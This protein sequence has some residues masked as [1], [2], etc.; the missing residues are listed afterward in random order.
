MATSLKSG[1]LVRETA[2]PLKRNYLPL[3][4]IGVSC[5]VFCWRSFLFH[6]GTAEVVTHV[7]PPAAGLHRARTSPVF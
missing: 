5:I 1:S 3:T 2:N 4:R 7:H 6:G